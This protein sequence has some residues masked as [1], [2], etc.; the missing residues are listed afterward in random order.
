M[1]LSTNE[2]Y[3]VNCRWG[4]HHETFICLNFN[5]ALFA[6]VQEPKETA[7][8]CHTVHVLSIHSRIPFGL[9]NVFTYSLP[10]RGSFGSPTSGRRSLARL[11]LLV[12]AFIVAQL[13]HPLRVVVIAAAIGA[14][15]VL[16]V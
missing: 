9:S 14:V 7:F 3:C 15:A 4:H 8:V 13:V 11:A 2:S 16:R 12:R 10:L 5:L 6:I 1:G